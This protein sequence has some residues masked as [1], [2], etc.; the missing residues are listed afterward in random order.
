MQSQALSLS[1]P[2]M[3]SRKIHN[4]HLAFANTAEPDKGLL[5]QVEDHPGHKNPRKG[6]IDFSDL[7][8]PGGR[9]E[10]VRPCLAK[11]E[12]SVGHCRQ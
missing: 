9:E 6:K 1:P 3:R 12:Q 7:L 5:Q 2:G 8:Q 10:C 11:S 4:W